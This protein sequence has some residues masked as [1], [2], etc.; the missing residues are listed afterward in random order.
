MK[1]VYMPIFI[2][3]LILILFFSFVSA[4][5][6]Y[7]KFKSRFGITGNHI[8]PLLPDEEMINCTDSDN[9]INFTQ[10]AHIDYSYRKIWDVTK[11]RSDSLIDECVSTIKIREYYCTKKNQT[12]YVQP[13]CSN[14]LIN[15]K[16]CYDATCR[17][18]SQC[19]FYDLKFK[20]IGDSE[21]INLINGEE[22][23]ISLYRFYRDE[24][25][26]VGFKLISIGPPYT[27]SGTGVVD[28]FLL[29]RYFQGTSYSFPP[30]QI[31]SDM[32][33]GLYGFN[34][35]TERARVYGVSCN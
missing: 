25:P 6:P 1:K 32:A 15:D 24:F 35:T 9:G 4:S 16:I 33:L 2:F 27:Y 26:G 3:L 11:V 8:L 10:P 19:K 12:A 14:I 7:D 28:I 31:S 18:R 22:V 29:K 5:T 30:R 23:N 13:R 34:R 20:G 21:I 17:L